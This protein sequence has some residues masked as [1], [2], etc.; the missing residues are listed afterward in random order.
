MLK[1]EITNN[2]LGSFLNLPLIEDYLLPT[3]TIVTPTYNRKEQ[4]EI[5]IRII[6]ILLIHEINYLG[7]FWMIHQQM[8]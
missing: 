3:V 4:F 7:L 1:V 5:A 6:K 8:N 2:E